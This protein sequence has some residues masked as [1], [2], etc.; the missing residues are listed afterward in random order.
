MSANGRPHC[1]MAGDHHRVAGVGR[2]RRHPVVLLASR[3]S[4]SRTRSRTRS[5]RP[6]RPS[7]EHDVA[8]RSSGL[9]TVPFGITNVNG[10]NVARRDR[11]VVEDVRVDVVGHVADHRLHVRVVRR[12]VLRRG[13]GEVERDLVALLDQR[14]RRGCAPARARCRARRRSSRSGTCRPATRR[15][16][17][18]RPPRPP[19]AS[20]A[21]RRRRS[22]APSRSAT[23]RMRVRT[24][25]AAVARALRSVVIICGARMPK[26]L[27]TSS[28]SV[29]QLVVL[30]DLDR[31]EV[32]PLVEAGG[33]R[34]R[35]AARL[36]R[37]RLGR[38]VGARRPTRSA[39]RRGRSGCT[40]TWS[41]L[42]MPP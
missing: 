24:R 27:K 34:H 33:G 15:S 4:S 26:A 8:A 39:S 35:H 12:E 11:Q 42:W 41:G 7:R 38:V 21:A 17:C 10:A 31:R 9:S 14:Q 13:A 20:A 2:A 16:A 40:I 28:M 6:C 5:S 37:A 22:P 3:T 36:D 18:A 25:S 30:A 19:A 29:A 32:Q 23:S 1:V